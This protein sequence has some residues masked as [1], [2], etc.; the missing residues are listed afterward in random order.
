[1]GRSHKSK[2]RQSAIEKRFEPWSS[3]PGAPPGSKPSID[4]N[5]RP[6]PWSASGVHGH[7]GTCWE[8]PLGQRWR[9]EATPT[10]MPV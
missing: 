10:P 1:M 6:A 2:S 7:G 8:S 4:G 9:S 5:P 3:G